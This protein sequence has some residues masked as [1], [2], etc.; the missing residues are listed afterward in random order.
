MSSN[1]Q[2]PKMPPGEEQQST[3]EKGEAD[4]TPSVF[5]KSRAMSTPKTALGNNVIKQT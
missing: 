3:Q 2:S 1:P 5:M 4:S